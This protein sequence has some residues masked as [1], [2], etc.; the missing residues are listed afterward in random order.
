MIVLLRKWRK[1]WVLCYYNIKNKYKLNPLTV[2]F[3]PS[4]ETKLGKE[5]LESFIAKGYDHVHI[6]GDKERC[7]S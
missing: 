6:T 5:N 4:M 3:R 1:R 7:V 2:T